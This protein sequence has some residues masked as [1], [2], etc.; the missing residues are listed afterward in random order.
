MP[1]NAPDDYND[2]FDLNRFVTAQEG[3]FDRVL[4]ELRS[5]QKRTHWMWFIF[6]QIVGLGY[7]P[8]AHYYAIKSRVE[9]RH[10][11][12]HPIHANRLRECAETLLALEGRSIL[13]K[14]AQTKT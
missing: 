14:L 10:Y 13:E 7:S 1:A 5:G 12:H 4:A 9:A 6:P 3:L 11:H 2:P 8:T